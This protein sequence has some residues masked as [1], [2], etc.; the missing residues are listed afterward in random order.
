[1]ANTLEP[2]HPDT[3]DPA[4]A[5]TAQVPTQPA[6]EIHMNRSSHRA[7]SLTLAALAA[8]LA[9]NL[10]LAAPTSP[11]LRAACPGVDAALQDA[12]SRSWARHQ[13]NGTVRIDMQVQGQRVVDASARSGP[14]AYRG[15]V[16]R[17]VRGLKCAGG[18]DELRTIS[19]DVQFTDAL[20][21]SARG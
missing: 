11:D 15:A 16:Q 12:L 21:A 3:R 9:A 14:V 13:L 19:F 5:G 20:D 18:S 4:E 8:T 10:A 1:M 2:R 17:A 6:K 7:G